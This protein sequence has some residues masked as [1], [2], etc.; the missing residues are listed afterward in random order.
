M[1]ISSTALQTALQHLAEAG[2]TAGALVKPDLSADTQAAILAINREIM[3]AQSSSIMAQH[4]HMTLLNRVAELERQI[5]QMKDRS[6]RCADYTPK[7]METGVTVYVLK[8]EKDL[9]KASHEVCPQCFRKDEISI[10]K[11]TDKSNL[12]TNLHTWF[13]AHECPSCKNAF[14]YGFVAKQASFNR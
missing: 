3:L 6:A 1:T 7:Q 10:L 4:E 12:W 13:R 9:P 8:T 14:D 2:K 11:P 5:T